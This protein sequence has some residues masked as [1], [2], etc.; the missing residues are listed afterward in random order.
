MNDTRPLH[1]RLM[2]EEDV[3]KV[4]LSCQGTRDE[5][6]ERILKLG[7]SAMLVFEGDVHIGQLQFRPYVADTVSPKGL[8]ESLFW[9]DFKGHAPALP[10]KTLA[11]FCY[12]V[13]QL[14]DT[15]K[16][17][18]RYFGRG[19][20]VTLLDETIAWAISQGFE[21]IVAKGCPDFKP[22]V[23][24]MGG[25]PASLYQTRK[26]HV[27]STYQDHDLRAT[28]AEMLAGKFGEEKQKDLA[29]IDLDK[30]CE[31]SVCVRMLT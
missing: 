1:Y 24:F 28:I 11:L 13:G 7:A 10:E 25:M 27:A 8:Y 26:F 15:E 2:T 23:E 31:V 30:A 5:V 12:H 29:G 18:A 6:L 21:A 4:P 3:S 16:R 22:I 19:I 9:M 14:D 20:G 17:D